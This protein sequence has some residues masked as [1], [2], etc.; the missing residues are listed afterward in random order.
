MCGFEMGKIPQVLEREP[1]DKTLFPC[2]ND[3]Y[4]RCI[5]MFG[6]IGN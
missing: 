1:R 4:R 6:F 2:E 5:E 3:V